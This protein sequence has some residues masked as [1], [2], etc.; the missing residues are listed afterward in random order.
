[1]VHGVPDQ[2]GQG[3]SDRL[4]EAPVELRL[5]PLQGEAD[6]LP[7]PGG[8]VPHHPGQLAEHLAHRLHS[9]L[10]HPLLQLARQE[11]ELLNGAV[12]LGGGAVGRERFVPEQGEEVLP[13]VGE[14][15][16]LLHSE[17]A[18][19]ALD[20]VHGAENPVEAGTVAGVVLQLHQ[21]P[22]HLLEILEALDREL[23]D[24]GI[25]VTHAASYL[26]QTS[27]PGPF[28]QGRI[29]QKGRQG[30][31]NRPFP[32]ILEITLQEEGIT[33]GLPLV[34][35]V[36][37]LGPPSLR[38]AVVPG[39]T[40]RPASLPAN[41]S[42]SLTD[43]KAHEIIQW[44]NFMTIDL[45]SRKDLSRAGFRFGERGTH[46][47][48]TIML[49][50]LSALFEAVPPGATRAEYTAAIVEDNALG[51]QT[52][53]TRRLTSQRLGEL[54]A[55]D[56]GVPVFRVLRRLWEL[57][58]AGRPLL[59]MLVALT[60]DPL[61]RGTAHGVLGLR[62]GEELV[63]TTFRTAIRE[64]VK[65]RLNESIL[66]KVA[67][68]TAS[69]WT[70][71]GHLVGRVRKIR[72]R[73]RPSVGPVVM[74]LWL[75]TLEGRAGMA[76]LETRWTRVLDTSGEALIAHVLQARRLGFLNARIGGGTVEIDARALDPA[77]AEV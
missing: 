7:A 32:E 54:Y 36:A 34:E 9:R 28:F 35:T 25:H 76:L 16:E 59:A 66:D 61:L 70:Q 24:D 38:G 63:R 48:R 2:V 13:G 41:L 71:S 27:A 31:C 11:V 72:T 58:P 39:L 37:P 75:G 40:V 12:A 23:V 19:R 1:M 10:H 57:D 46:T 33:R 15:L 30:N 50:E 77:M 3:V 6:P 4:Q 69:S 26:P 56:P 64:V 60:R 14:L 21:I 47:S 55:L 18:P 65:D 20:C 44:M 43:G 49:A 68:N 5:L 22:V 74:A 8:Q 42:V 73:V 51:K 29:G 52:V 67:R 53:A 17:E 45:S 62:P